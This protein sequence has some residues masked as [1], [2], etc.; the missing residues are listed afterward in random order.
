M[1]ISAMLL[2]KNVAL[3]LKVYESQFKQSG[4]IPHLFQSQVFSC[5]FCKIFKNRIPP[6]DC[7]RMISHDFLFKKIW[8]SNFY[9]KWIVVFIVKV[10]TK[11]TK[12]TTWWRAW[13]QVLIFGQWCSTA[14][15]NNNA[16]DNNND[17]ALIRRKL[18]T[19]L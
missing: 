10:L 9:N 1:L 18:P 8:K 17:N 6:D 16:N 11:L 5:N 13:I 19:F 7:F 15:N 14:I 2:K 4:I 12:T 3:W